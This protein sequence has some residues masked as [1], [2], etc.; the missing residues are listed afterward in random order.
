MKAQFIWTANST[1][2]NSV[3]WQIQASA[4]TDTEALDR[5]W[6]SAVTVTDANGASAYTNRTTSQTGTFTPA[7]YTAG[8]VT[9]LQ[10]RVFRDPTN[11]SD[12]LAATARLI[13]VVLEVITQACS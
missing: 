5:T 3:V 8:K 7:G 13:G 11:G 6:S 12:N 9:A 2:T 10:I 4:T 1:S